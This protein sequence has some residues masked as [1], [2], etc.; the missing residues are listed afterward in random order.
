MDA[1]SHILSIPFLLMDQLSII[2]C[3]FFFFWHLLILLSTS[4]A[5][6]RNKFHKFTLKVLDLFQIHLNLLPSS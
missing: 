4:T 6:F 3:L 1:K 2:I 5:Y